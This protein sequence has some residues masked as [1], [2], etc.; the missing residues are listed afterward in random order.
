MARVLQIDLAN[1]LG[2]DVERT[3]DD[4]DDLCVTLFDPN[5]ELRIFC[6]GAA[7]VESLERTLTA[8][9]AT[10]AAV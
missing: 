10:L 9:R 3:H 8:V 5:G 7:F 2:V 4:A 6:S 1:D